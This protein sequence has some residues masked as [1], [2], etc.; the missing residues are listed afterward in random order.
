GCNSRLRARLLLQETQETLKNP[1]TETNALAPKPILESLLPDVQ[2]CQQIA[3]P[4]SGEDRENVRRAVLQSG[5]HSRH[6][7]L[8]GVPI[9]SDPVTFGNENVDLCLRQCL[10]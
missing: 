5:L 6:V 10:P 4:E 1:F 3:A 9:E 2:A 8:D 7:R